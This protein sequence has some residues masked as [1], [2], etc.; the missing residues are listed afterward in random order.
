MKSQAKDAAT[1]KRLE[2]RLQLQ[3]VRTS[4]QQ[5]DQL[6]ADE[7]LEFGS[8]GATYDKEQ[9]IKGLLA[10]PESQLPRYATMQGMKVLWLAPEIALVT[11][12]SQK[13]RP[14][15]APPQRAN[16]SSI[17]K[18]MDG[19]WQLV[20]HQGTPLGRSPDKKKRGQ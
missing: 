18:K 19:R 7:F 12:R 10:D 3:S 15:G 13:S 14:G 11:Y 17:W 6:L 4:R 2:T 1:L 9:V 5:L 16:R 8:S 20:F